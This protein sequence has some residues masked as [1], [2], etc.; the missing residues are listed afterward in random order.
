MSLDS[1]IQSPPLAKE[2]LP[3]VPEAA[4]DQHQL[5][6]LTADQPEVET[7]TTESGTETV[8]GDVTVPQLL[9]QGTPM[10][11]V[12][13]KDRKR[14]VFR[15][16]PDIGQIIWESKKHRISMSMSFSFSLS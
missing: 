8:V 12:S 9:Q 14:A 11:K 1:K 5:A 7:P 10:T 13:A 3:S 6:H 15:L 4:S 2:R 16:D